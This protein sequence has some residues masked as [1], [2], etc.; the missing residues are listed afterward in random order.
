MGSD[1]DI[2]EEVKENRVQ[3]EIESRISPMISCR[4]VL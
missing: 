1:A 2:A 3:G 4:V